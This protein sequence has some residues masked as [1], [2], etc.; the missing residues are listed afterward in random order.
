MEERGTPTCDSRSAV[1]YHKAELK[2]IVSRYLLP[3]E[4]E[5]Y[6]GTTNKCAIHENCSAQL[7]IIYNRC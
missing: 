7:I 5:S 4:E 1:Q 2:Y 6:F 3:Y